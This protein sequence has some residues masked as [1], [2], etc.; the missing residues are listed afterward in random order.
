MQAKSIDYEHFQYKSGNIKAF[1]FLKNEI[2]ASLYL[3]ITRGV[4]NLNE[5]KLNLEDFKNEIKELET[6]KT[7]KEPCITNKDN[8]LQNSNN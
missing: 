7:L 3:K 5:T 1:N 4:S 2:P 8:G 6:K